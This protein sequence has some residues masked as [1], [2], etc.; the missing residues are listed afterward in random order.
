MTVPEILFHL[1]WISI[2]CHRKAAQQNFT[3][4]QRFC[5]IIDTDH[6][7]IHKRQSLRCPIHTAWNKTNNMF[8]KVMESYYG[9]ET[10]KLVGTY[11]I[12]VS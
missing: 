3:F 5:S 8:N 1:M 10:C 4:Y 7:N 2:N 11:P 6:A 9:A 12:Y